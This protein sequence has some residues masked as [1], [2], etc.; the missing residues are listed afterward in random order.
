M[1]RSWLRSRHKPSLVYEPPKDCPVMGRSLL[2]LGRLML[3]NNQVMSPAMIIPIGTKSA[4]LLCDPNADFPIAPCTTFP[5]VISSVNPANR[6]SARVFHR[7]CLALAAPAADASAVA[8]TPP[9][10]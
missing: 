7:S 4:K 1:R 5:I 3:V 9:A 2:Y 10:V 8:D 6:L